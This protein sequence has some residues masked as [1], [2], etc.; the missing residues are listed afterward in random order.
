MLGATEPEPRSATGAEHVRC[1]EPEIVI[2]ELQ[3]VVSD[4]DPL[5]VCEFD[6]DI[7]FH[8]GACLSRLIDPPS[9]TEREERHQPPE[10]E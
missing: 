4:T 6:D 9:L 2:D 8:S 3:L 1:P 5:A 7:R 10:A